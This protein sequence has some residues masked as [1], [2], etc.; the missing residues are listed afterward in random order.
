MQLD[1]WTKAV[2]MLI[3]ISLAVIAWKLPM[4][5]TSYAQLGCGGIADNPCYISTGANPLRV[6]VQPP[7]AL[8]VK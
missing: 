2:L 3:A 1:F 6:S 4:S 5:G 8:E 7:S